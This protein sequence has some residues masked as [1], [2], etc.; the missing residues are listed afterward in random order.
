MSNSAKYFGFL[1]PFEIPS[2]IGRL[3]NAHNARLDVILSA[4]IQ[5]HKIRDAH[6]WDTTFIKP[7]WQ[8]LG[9]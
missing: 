6:I 8:T 7:V 5:G 4:Q 1:N 2:Q 3:I 9:E